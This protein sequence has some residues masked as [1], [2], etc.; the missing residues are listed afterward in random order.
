[1]LPDLE[2]SLRKAYKVRTVTPNSK[3]CEVGFPRVVIE[4][5]ARKLGLSVEDFLERYHAVANYDSFEGT[6]YT[7]EKDKE[8][9]GKP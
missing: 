4:R 6:I 2:K 5:E 9:D 1:M 7:F 8:L 3:Y